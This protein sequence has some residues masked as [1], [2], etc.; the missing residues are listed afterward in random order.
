MH[1][2]APMPPYFALQLHEAGE[3]DGNKQQQQQQQQQ[4]HQQR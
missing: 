4:Q 2:F 3:A 1:D